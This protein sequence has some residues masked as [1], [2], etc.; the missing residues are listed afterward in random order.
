MRNRTEH[1]N[2]DGRA[3]YK[4]FHNKHDDPAI[5]RAMCIV[6][7]FVSIV[8]AT[9]VGVFEKYCKTGWT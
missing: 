3:I 1:L 7:T 2:C 8:I 6:T 5:F 9:F 4:V